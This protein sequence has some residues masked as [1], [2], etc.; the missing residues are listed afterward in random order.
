MADGQAMTAPETITVMGWPKRLEWLGRTMRPDNRV[1]LLALVFTALAELG[2]REQMPRRSG[3][4][5]WTSAPR[6]TR[7]D[8]TLTVITKPV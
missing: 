4:T 8:P 5:S 1:I 7:S 3:A 6:L 2:Y